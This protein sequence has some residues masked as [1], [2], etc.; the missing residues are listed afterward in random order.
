M[1][2]VHLSD[3][4]KSNAVNNFEEFIKPIVEKKLR[5]GF[6]VAIDEFG[7][8]VLYLND[9]SWQEL[10]YLKQCLDAHIMK[11]LLGL[12]QKEGNA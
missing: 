11:D 12:I 9:M 4:V 8:G 3:A 2:I 1:K 6:Y 7:E 10:A 5:P